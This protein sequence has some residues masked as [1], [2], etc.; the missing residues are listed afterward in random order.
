MAFSLE[1]VI[2]LRDEFSGTMNN[3]TKKAEGFQKSFGGWDK[4]QKSMKDTSK[5]MGKYVTAPLTGVGAAAVATVSGFDDSMS[6][7]AAISGASGGDFDKLRSAAQEFG[8]ST[9]HSA[10]AAADG[11]SYLALAGYDTEQIMGA[12]PGMLDLATAS[13]MD[14]ASTADIISDT[15]SQFGMDA[16][17][18]GKAADV[19]AKVSS[20]ANTGV[21]ELGQAM[22]YAGGA[23]HNAGMDLSDAS[24]MLG[25]F[26][27][28]GLKGSQAGTTFTAMLN[29]MQ[30][31][32]EDG[33]LDFDAF[34]VAMYDA[35]GE[36]RNMGDIMAD[37][38]RATAGMSDEQ[39]DAAMAQVFNTQAMKGVNAVMTEGTEEY[40]KLADAARESNGAASEMASIM[41]DNLGG[42]MREMRSA[43][44]GLLIEIGD[45]L[46][47]IVSD[48]ADTIGEWARKFGELDEGT[49]R[50][51]IVLGIAAAAIAPLLGFM[52]MAITVAQKLAA[53]FKALAAMKALFNA[54]MLLSPITWIILGIVALI[55]IGVLLWKNWDTVTEKASELWDNLTTAFGGIRDGVT[56]AMESLQ[57]KMSGIWEGITGTIKSAVN[58]IIGFVNKMIG[59]MN[60]ISIDIPSWVPDSLGGGKSFGVNIP[61]IPKI[62]GS[63][64]HGVQRVPYDMTAQLHKGERVQTAN[65]VKAQEKGGNGGINITL[66]YTG[67]NR[68]SREDAREM[69]SILQS[70][71]SKS[72]G[73]MAR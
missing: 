63:Y 72:W 1:A 7:V 14:L 48:M 6:R 27:N 66:N 56:D 54:T 37:V 39:R 9:A 29:D 64:F 12:M 40:F 51:I 73:A 18:A 35:D 68:S 3:V 33:I 59:G 8:S 60:A 71:L 28:T 65:E 15:M 55:A 49:Q 69:V 19:F 62:S 22:T 20:S 46:A 44:E 25:L 30:N 24:A 5:S 36:M 31:S 4:A 58:G 43:I 50:V 38:E 41:G 53:G 42:S 45:H 47:P 23:A 13:G 17:D 57:D 11:M 70:E 52:A 32:V 16:N 61:E 10:S 26:G 2:R 67:S 21:G 34:T